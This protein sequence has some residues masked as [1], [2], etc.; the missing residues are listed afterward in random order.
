MCC[1]ADR[2]LQNLIHVPGP[3]E[4]NTIPTPMMRFVTHS[5]LNFQDSHHF[6][7]NPQGCSPR[8]VFLRKG[9]MVDLVEGADSPKLE[10]AI[11]GHIVPAPS[12]EEGVDGN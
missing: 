11:E 6:A 5:H 1:E 10:A 2:T 4:A 12:G 9:V 3:P 7:W 8:F